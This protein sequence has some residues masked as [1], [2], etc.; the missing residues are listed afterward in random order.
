MRISPIN[1]NYQPCK[2]RTKTNINV[3]NFAFQGKHDTAKFLGG[4]F[5]SLGTI[6]AI[7]GTTIM[8]G[9][10][11]LPFVLGYGALSAGSGAILGHMIDKGN[12]EYNKN[13]K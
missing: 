9:G 1:V 10:A 8:T 7:I 13:K 2:Q 5:G 12:P 11:S 3:Q 4:V 6:G